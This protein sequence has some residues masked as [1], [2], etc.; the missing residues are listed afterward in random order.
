MHTNF[1]VIQNKLALK[2]D[3][4]WFH[5]C[6]PD[7][8]RSK[9]GWF[10]TSPDFDRDRKSK[11]QTFGN[12]NKWSPLSWPLSLYAPFTY[13]VRQKG[14]SIRFSSFLQTRL[15]LKTAILSKA[16]WNPGKGDPGGFWM[17]WILNGSV[18]NFFGPWLKLKS[19]PL[20]TEPFEIWFAKS[21][22]F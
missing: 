6:D 3:S 1:V 9:R 12:P 20:K 11:S 7:F 2:I 17:F 8:E 22:D 4:W 13:F 21:L 15:T 14:F 10:A 5:F 16:I 18:F 19:D